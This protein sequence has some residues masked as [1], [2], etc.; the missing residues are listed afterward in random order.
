MKYLLDTCV[1]SELVAKR[2]DPMVTAWIDSI[3]SDS[4]FRVN[5]QAANTIL[6]PDMF[7][8]NRSGISRSMCM[9]ALRP[10]QWVGTM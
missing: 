1:I 3:D 8:R 4:N 2:P 5:F 7:S 9:E 10:V 6:V